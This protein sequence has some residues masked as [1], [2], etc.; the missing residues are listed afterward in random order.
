MD[1]SKAHKPFLQHVKRECRRYRI[2]LILTEDDCFTT[3]GQ[4]YGG[5]FSHISRELGVTQLNNDSAF[6]SILVHEFSH[7]EQW[8]DNDPSYTQHLRGGYESSTIMENW[9]DG[10]EYEYDT[11][12]KAIALIRDCE[13]NCERRS[14]IN[15]NKYA[16]DIDI[17]IYCKSANAYI[18]FYN[19]IMLKRRWEYKEP[20]SIIPMI[21][22]Q[23]PTDLYSLDYTT[24]TSEHIK[25]FDT[26]LKD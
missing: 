9:L 18:L 23:M 20:A 3:D 24:L 16:L 22:N 11:I 4:S 1:Y 21:I 19:Y 5:Y 17:D 8:I 14:I 2:K 26:Y 25:L 10:R 7:M 12:H 6:T 15:I 13:L